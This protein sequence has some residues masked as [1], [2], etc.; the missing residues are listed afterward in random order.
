MAEITERMAT[1]ILAA[2]YSKRSGDTVKPLMRIGSRTVAE[3]AVLAHLDAGISDVRMVVGYRADDVIAAV[4]HLG[5]HIVR[6]EHFERGM[7]SSVQAGVETLP[8]WI[9]AFFIMPVDIPLVDPASIRTILAHY[10]KNHCGIIYPTYRGQRGHPT[11]ISRKYIPEILISEA[12][13]GLKGLL[14][15]HDD[16]AC[17][18]TLDDKAVVMDIDTQEDYLR[19]LF[20]RDRHDV[21]GREKCLELLDE[22]K[23][24]D[25]VKQH[26][27]QVAA[28]ACRLVSLLNKTGAGLNMNLVRAAALLHDIQRNRKDHALAGAEYLRTCGY[29]Q[30]SEIV[31]QH[32]D[33]KVSD[34]VIPTEAE[35]VYLADKLVIGQRYV[36]LHERFAAALAHYQSDGEA[37]RSISRRQ[38][39]AEKIQK[40]VE[41]L[42]G[43]ALVKTLPAHRAVQE[44]EA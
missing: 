43:C 6:N 12:P 42:I 33:I 44:Q 13:N 11:L 36:P 21:P 35:V 3:H 5:I 30:V 25:S 41:N 29:L 16:D 7:F 18:L 15:S 38:T 17:C 1:I 10:E 4:Q 2:G 32:M 31:A 37:C 26:C 34:C 14:Y 8:P 39:Q 20:Y 22:A 19:L 28:V 9:E 24:E 23:V 27:K 40:K